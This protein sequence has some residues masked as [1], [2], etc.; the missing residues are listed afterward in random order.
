MRKSKIIQFIVFGS[1]III[2]LYLVNSETFNIRFISKITLYSLLII[3]VMMIGKWCYNNNPS[4]IDG[5]INNEDKV[6][7]VFLLMLTLLTLLITNFQSNIAREYEFSKELT[8][9][10][11][12]LDLMEPIYKSM[13]L[14]G[15]EQYLGITNFKKDYNPSKKELT[16]RHVRNSITHNVAYLLL[17]INYLV[18]GWLY[19][20][21]KKIKNG[22]TRKWMVKSSFSL[23]A[24][25]IITGFIAN[26]YYFNERI[27]LPYILGILCIVFAIFIL[28]EFTILSLRISK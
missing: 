4:T 1:I 24:I 22:N 2:L 12:N 25:T 20:L 3:L 26:L 14:T 9:R 21:I 8:Y 17:M 10:Y 13:N 16:L 18:V 23:V 6:L 28:S 19:F 7:N 15:T 27:M 5:I 11:E